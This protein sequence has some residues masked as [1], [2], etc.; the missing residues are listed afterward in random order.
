[1]VKCWLQWFVFMLP[2][3]GQYAD[4]ARITALN[5]P[6]GLATATSAE[7]QCAA[8]S[9]R[10]NKR[11]RVPDEERPT[12]A[13]QGLAVDPASLLL[14]EEDEVSVSGSHDGNGASMDSDSEDNGLME[15]VC[16]FLLNHHWP[17]V[18]Y[19]IDARSFYLIILFTPALYSLSS[20]FSGIIHVFMTISV[21]LLGYCS[22]FILGTCVVDVVR[23]NSDYFSS[24]HA[25]YFFA[26]NGRPTKGNG[27]RELGPHA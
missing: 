18:M 2:S 26:T 21:G 10:R 6:G 9:P 19:C 16:I 13:Q 15:Q 22:S 27:F 25:D 7:S 5:S 3:N 24:A 20:L 14:P 8:T 4:V 1:M 11:P 23:L 12:S 17:F